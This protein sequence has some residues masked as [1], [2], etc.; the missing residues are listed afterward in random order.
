MSKDYADARYGVNKVICGFPT[1]AAQ[2]GTV[3]SATT[4]ATKLIPYKTDPNVLTVRFPVGGTSA[5]L[6]VV[7][8]TATPFAAG[9]MGAVGAIGTFAI[10]TQANETDAQFTFPASAVIQAGDCIILQTFGTTAAV[11]TL[12]VDVWGN[13]V[14]ANL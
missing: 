11:Y 2:N 12:N 3:A 6:M 10:G 9:T 1:T 5:G 8:G 4:I 13:E 14:F 7:I